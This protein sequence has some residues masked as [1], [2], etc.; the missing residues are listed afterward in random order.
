[1]RKQ[2]P[3][4]QILFVTGRL[5]EKAL[6]KEVALLEAE[7]GFVG[8]VQVLPISVAAL[9]TAQWILKKIEVPEGTERIIVP[10]YCNDVETIER[11]L[12]VPVECGPKDLRRLNEHFGKPADHLEDYGQYEI[13]IIAEINEAPGIPLAQILENAQAL[14]NDGADII[15]LG[16]IPGYQWPEI[17]DTVQAL[18]DQGFRV[19]VDSLN[20][21]EIAPA[22]KA[23][24]ELVL[25][26]NSTNLRHSPDWGVEVVAIPDDFENFQGLQQ[27]M[28]FL[29]SHSVPFR[30]DPILE[31]IGFGFGQSLKRYLDIRSR[32]PEV[33][34]MMGI[35]NITE[36]TDCDSAGINVLLL[37]ICQEL[38]IHSVLTTQVINWARSSIKECDIARRLVHF[39]I[40]HGVPPKRLDD[41]L[42]VLR[43]SKLFCQDDESLDELAAKIRDHNFR[44][45]ADQGKIHL[46]GGQQH[47]QSKDPFQVFDQAMDHGFTNL[48]ASHS[49]Y[50]GFEMCK[51]MIAN[52]LGKEYTQDQALN[53]G[54]LTE[55]ERDR[56]R[57]RKR[58]RN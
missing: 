46:L 28:E 30:V 45:F 26:V 19:S 32:F 29:D 58:T 55:I 22:A 21:L 14:K 27:T 12:G 20:P 36:L 38:N 43:D 34:I 13:E 40:Q 10:G 57:L 37:A 18:R 51:A 16:C 11:Q 50:L 52:Q 24:A 35:G 23:G 25:S 9:M 44:I 56:H 33:E 54:H 3:Q 39:S 4:D 42:V 49:F 17:G 15:D 8:T 41:R 47:F 48:D 1:G 7:I 31:P 5:A 2:M 53:W 6:R